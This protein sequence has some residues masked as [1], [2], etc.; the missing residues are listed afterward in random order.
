MENTVTFIVFIYDFAN[1]DRIYICA[2][3][4]TLFL[5]KYVSHDE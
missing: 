5:L 2:L 4:A 3:L 1:P